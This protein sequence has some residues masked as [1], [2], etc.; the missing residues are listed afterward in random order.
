[1]VCTADVTLDRV[2]APDLGVVDLI[3]ERTIARSRPTIVTTLGV[4][5]LVSPVGPHPTLTS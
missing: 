5:V 3:N 2:V 4:S 1:M